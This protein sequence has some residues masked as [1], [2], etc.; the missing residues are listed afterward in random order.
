MQ[1]M[2]HIGQGCELHGRH[3]GLELSNSHAPDTCV[4]LSRCRAL[5]AQA[6]HQRMVVTSRR[7]CACVTALRQ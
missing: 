5:V 1:L 2:W 3:R 7:T 6:L 4:D